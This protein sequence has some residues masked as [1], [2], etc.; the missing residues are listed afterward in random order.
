MGREAVAHRLAA[1]LSADAVGY[2][3]LM[4]EDEA[5][6]IRTLTDYREEIAMLVRQHE[7]RVVDAPGDNVL[8]EFPSAIEAVRCA[9]ELQGV[10]RGRNATLPRERRM[11][12]RVGVHLGEVAVDGE[13]LYGD[14][15]NIAARL[16]AMGEPGGVFISGTVHEQVRHKLALDFADLGERQ[17]K[18]FP[19]P[20]RVYRVREEQRAPPRAGRRQRNTRIALATAA[21]V[22]V[23]GLAVWWLRPPPAHDFTVEGFDDVPAVAVL[24]FCNLSGDPE[25]AYFADGLAEDLIT[26]LSA[27]RLPVIARN[28]SFTFDGCAADVEQVGREL[29][30][31]YV[32]EGSVRRAGER[33]RISAQLIDA[34]TGHHVWAETYDRVLR[35]I[36]A[37]QDEITG[38]IVASAASELYSTETERTM[39]KEPRDLGAYDL[40]MRGGWH[41]NK[42]T[43]HDNAKA[44]SL[45]ERA[46]ERDPRY[47]FAFTGVA[48]THYW[49]ILFQ[50]SDAPERSVAELS[51]AARTSVSLDGEDPLGQVA[52]AAAY[53][54]T[55]QGDKV[56]A[57]LER[58]IAKDPSMVPA[59]VWLGMALAIRRRPDEGIAHLETAMR[60]SPRDRLM[61][62]VFEGVALAHFAADRYQDAADCRSIPFS[63]RAG[64]SSAGSTRRGA[65][66]R[67]SCG[68][69][70]T[71]PEPACR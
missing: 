62:A 9:V 24:R 4:A 58:A 42:L 63:P 22:L 45:F 26:R 33:V 8:A 34:T 53:G 55:G 46:S 15:V 39:R 68:C 36:F 71:S 10:L 13:R 20:I 12:F 21:V 51:R 38:V 40:V 14:G 59:R 2:S 56:I 27:K 48:L 61:F 67:S 16:E 43:P 18:N 25:Q 57:A 37:V 32:V 60:L 47:A 64:L 6:T 5:A 49:D 7:G 41:F 30:A 19:D 66:S 35:D 65:P 44:R 69:S 54:L 29:R 52:L 17:V 50:W 28:S 3:R 23:A 70:R 31:R 11:E 1:I